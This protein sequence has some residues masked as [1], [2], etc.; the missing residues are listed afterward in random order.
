MSVGTDLSIGQ[1]DA[2]NATLLVGVLRLLD[3]GVGEEAPPGQVTPCD[4][5]EEQPE[6]QVDDA[7][8]LVGIGR[9]RCR[10]DAGEVGRRT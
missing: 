3:R 9:Q 8:G 6:R 10:A 5:P 1:I 2:G 4:R 7:P